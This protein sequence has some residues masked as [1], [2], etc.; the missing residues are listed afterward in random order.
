MRPVLFSDWEK[1][2][3]EEVRRG[4]RLGKPREKIVLID[5]MLAISN[6]D[7]SSNA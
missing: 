7:S 3:R 1:I 4:G 5:E 6:S 2:D